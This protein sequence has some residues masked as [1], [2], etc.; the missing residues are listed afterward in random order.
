MKVDRYSRT[1]EIVT[2]LR[3]LGDRG[4]T[5]ASSFRDECAAQLLRPAGQTALRLADAILCRSPVAM[6]A[7]VIAQ[8]DALALR[9]LAIDDAGSHAEA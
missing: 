5:S 6:Q 2:F 4:W 9:T 1:A 7:R 8:I 3:A